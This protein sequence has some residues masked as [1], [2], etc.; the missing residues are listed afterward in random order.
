ML[1]Q[2]CMCV[3]VF[4]F[5]MKVAMKTLGSY[6]LPLFQL[7]AN[8]KYGNNFHIQVTRNGPTQQAPW[9]SSSWS[10]DGIFC[11]NI[12]NPFE[13]KKKTVLFHPQI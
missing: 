5:S 3:C 10:L 8:Y 13:K 6:I 7:Q 9:P 1:I 11:C 4:Q 12:E 2:V